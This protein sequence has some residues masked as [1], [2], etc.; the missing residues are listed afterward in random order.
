MDNLEKLDKEYILNT[1]SRDYTH[2]VYGNGSRIYT[3]N[4]I[5]YIDFTSGIG[6]NSLGHN[7]KKL[8]NAINTQASKLIHLSNLFLIE[9]QVKLAKKMV[10][11]SL[12]KMKV[13]FC[14]S[15][16]EANECAIKIARKYGKNSSRFKIITLKN[17]FHGRSIATLKACGQDKMHKHFSPFPDGFLYA[18]NVSE[19]IKIAKNDKE[20]V[21]I[22]LELI[23]GEGGVYAIPKDSILELEQFCRQNDVLLM[24]DEVQSGIYRSGEFL[25]SNLYNISPDVI[26]IA[27]GLAGGIPI[28][29]TM[30]NKVDIFSPSDHGSTFGG[31][32]LSTSA[33]ICVLDT[34]ESY[35][36]SNKLKENIDIF[37]DKLEYIANKYD[38]IKEVSGIGFMRGLKI[39]NDETLSKII[40]KARDNHLLLLKSGNSTLRF[41][42]AI[43][44]TK[45]EIYE[46]FYRLSKALDSLK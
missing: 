39:I 37:N 26:S 3:N 15:G 25:A 20:V 7:N 24:I 44:I 29:A 30:T 31:N 32:P 36:K 6:V 17:S 40:N 19:A 43:N 18:S 38:F 16:L 41:L 33:A 10:D 2:F 35:K 4:N 45:D 9:S 28:G 27:K 1:Y 13:F 21:G 14:N 8:I 46:G 34:L 23:Q 11:L 12:Y 5:E 42:P 22:L